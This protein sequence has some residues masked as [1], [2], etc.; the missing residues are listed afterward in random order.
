MEP[1]LLAAIAQHLEDG[2]KE[3][4]RIAAALERVYPEA[5]TGPV[6]CPACKVWVDDGHILRHEDFSDR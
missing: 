2:V 4:A 5:A 1:L 6:W 3:L